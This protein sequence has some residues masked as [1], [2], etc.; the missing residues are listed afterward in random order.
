MG[1]KERERGGTGKA[2]FQE[3]ETVTRISDQFP[4]RPQSSRDS[5][6]MY[7]AKHEQ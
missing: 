1:L 6:D 2:P 5:S 4:R 3:E 7:G